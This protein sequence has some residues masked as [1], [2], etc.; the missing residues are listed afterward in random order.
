MCGAVTALCQTP[1]IDPAVGVQN[2]GTYQ[3][4]AVAP[5]SFVAIFGTNFASSLSQA[6]TVPLS[7]APLGG[8]SV[9]FNGVAA[10]M[11]AVGHDTTPSHDDQINAQ[12]PWDVLAG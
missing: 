5:G 10:P 6:S 7:V 9:T 12:L 2:A 3:P 11:V 1:A 8:V 4:G